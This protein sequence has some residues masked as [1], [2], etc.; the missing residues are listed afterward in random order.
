MYKRLHGRNE[1]PGAGIGLSVCKKIAERH[2]GRMWVES[3]LGTGSTFYV[4]LP[5]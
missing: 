5:G 2:S 3:S 4:A 1:L